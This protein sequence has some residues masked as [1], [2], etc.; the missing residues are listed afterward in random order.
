[1]DDNHEE[2]EK[3][4]SES[5]SSEEKVL[6]VLTKD[7]PEHE[8]ETVD[9]VLEELARLVEEILDHPSDSEK[10]EEA[11]KQIEAVLKDVPQDLKEVTKAVAE[12]SIR[13]AGNEAAN[14]LHELNLEL[15]I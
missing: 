14:E 13:K 10:S 2:F 4:E 5:M 11:L 7:R 1:M 3:E 6:A 8:Q 15:G 12:N 9:N